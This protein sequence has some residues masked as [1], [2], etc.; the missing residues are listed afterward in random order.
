KILHAIR[1]GKIGG[2]ESHVIDLVENLDRHVYESVVLA[3]TDGPMISRMK[4]LG[5][6]TYIIPT[7]RP[8]DITKWGE[9]G[10]LLDRER[11]DIVH[12]HGTRAHSNTFSS[13]RRRKIP[14]VYT[15]HGWSFHP[16][17]QP[18]LRWLRIRG[19]RFL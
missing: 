3:F 8:F 10:R 15:V 6:K 4:S 12:A 17:Q 11:I 2:G 14:I 16:D 19:E 13:A 5:V 1:Q 18:V 9:V 7:E